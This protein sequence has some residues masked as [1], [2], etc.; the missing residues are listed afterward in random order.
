MPNFQLL[1]FL[2]NAYSLVHTD[3]DWIYQHW[4]IFLQCFGNY[5]FISVLQR[6]FVWSLILWLSVLQFD[7]YQ[8][9]GLV[10][11]PDKTLFSSLIPLTM[12]KSS[13]ISDRG[14]HHGPLGATEPWKQALPGWRSAVGV[15]HTAHFKDVG[16]KDSPTVS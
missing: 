9:L 2:F 10:L 3:F 16:Q 13:R 1:N 7:L 6:F 4:F 11:L 5:T 12:L 8:H 14:S 15:R